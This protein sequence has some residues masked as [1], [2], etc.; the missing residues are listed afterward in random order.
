[1]IDFRRARARG[2]QNYEREQPQHMLYELVGLSFYCNSIAFF[3]AAAL[4]DGVLRDYH[5]WDEIYAIR[6]PSY[7]K[8][9]SIGY[10]PEK[11]HWPLFPRSSLTRH[12]DHS[13]S[14]ASFDV[15][16][17]ARPGLS[18][19]L[20][21]PLDAACCSTRGPHASRQL[22]LFLQ[23]ADALRRSHQP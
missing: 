19:R 6:R 5:T 20:S 7:Q 18:G 17:I 10:V 15:Q 9:V 2:L 23:R 1:M 21:K 16:G 8:H 4:A 13:R 11:S 3:I 22:W 12:L 14:S